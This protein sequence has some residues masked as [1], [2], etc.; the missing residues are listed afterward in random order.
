MDFARPKIIQANEILAKIKNGKPAEYENVTIK[1][2]LNLERLTL[3]T[4]RVE[5]AR[6]DTEFLVLDEFAKIISISIQIRNSNIQ[7]M[8]TFTNI[9]FVYS[10]I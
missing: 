4:E 3:P 6:F 8:V 10:A 7:N 9:I 1:G 2:N 5:R